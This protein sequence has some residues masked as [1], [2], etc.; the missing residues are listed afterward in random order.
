MRNLYQIS[1]KRKK[2][3]RYEELFRWGPE[4][5]DRMMKQMK[6]M[7]FFTELS[8]DHVESKRKS[9][10]CYSWVTTDIRCNQHGMELD[11]KYS[12]NDPHKSKVY[13]YSKIEQ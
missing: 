1:L 6:R 9:N 5:R 11:V 3:C 4:I 12:R 8:K 2:S 7:R 10:N 13:K